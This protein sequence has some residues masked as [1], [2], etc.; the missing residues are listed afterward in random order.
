MCENPGKLQSYLLVS[1][2]FYLYFNS[3][4]ATPCTSLY[5]GWPSGCI[6]YFPAGGLSNFWGNRDYCQMN[7]GTDVYTYDLASL[8]DTNQGLLRQPC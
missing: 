1:A 2:N 5:Y 8:S 4:P 3:A 7:S 6:Q